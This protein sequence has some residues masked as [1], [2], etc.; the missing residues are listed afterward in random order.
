MKKF[1]AIIIALLMLV[2]GVLAEES[3]DPLDRL[4]VD[5]KHFDDTITLTTARSMDSTASFDE[6]DPEKTSY[7]QNRWNNTILELLNIEIDY[8]WIATDAD[9]NMT[10]WS[11]AL[12]S[13]D[14]PDYGVVS[15]E[16]YQLLVEMDLVADCT[17][18]WENYISD[19]YKALV[20]ENALEQMTFDG[21][22]LGIPKPNMGYSPVLLFVRQDWLDAL[23]L[24]FPQTFDEIVS[25]A[26]AFQEAKMGG[27]DTLGLLVANT[28][29]MSMSGIMN[30]FNAQLDY[31][32]ERDGKMAWSNIQPEMREALLQMQAL[33][34]DGVIN[35]DCAVATLDTVNEYIVS[36]KAGIFYAWCT[37]PCTTLQPLLSS[38]LDAA[39]S[40]ST[41]KGV[42]GEDI[43]FQT[44]TPTVGK[45]FV[46]KK[47][48]N[49]EAVANVINLYEELCCTTDSELY[50]MYSWGQDG[51]P[52]QKYNPVGGDRPVCINNDIACGNEI[53]LALEAGATSSEEYDFQLADAKGWFDPTLEGKNGVREQLWWYY[54]LG[55]EGTFTIAYDAY[56]K[57][58]HLDN[59]YVGL[60][61]ATMSLMGDIINDQLDT[62]MYEVIMGADISVY[63][64]ACEAW[65]A[66]GGQAITDEVNEALG[67]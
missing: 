49:L 58:L 36:G 2:P 64:Q 10:R 44:T 5:Y 40:F 53:R 47:C 3:S 59:G 21:K 67:L 19:R 38:D 55:E 31:W 9:S 28:D 52:W 24:D 13:N 14:L 61:T 33:Y 45:I 56:V 22:L 50:A 60:P 8:K 37:T 57:G 26:K 42:N 35:A 43:M 62:A 12:A 11:T 6:S 41:I 29:N 63:D 30:V 48:E 32:V 1:L 7:E 65:L 16:V 51:F 15:D 17:E 20:N 66:N 34:Q 25:T 27:E 23:G 54:T 39:F 4:T 18:M 46:S